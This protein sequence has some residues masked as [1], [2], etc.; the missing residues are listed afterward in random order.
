[1]E[2][3]TYLELN[4]TGIKEL[5]ESIEN[6]VSLKVLYI[7]GCKELESL[8]NSLCNLKNLLLLDLGLCSTLQKLPPLPPFLLILK[9]DECERL[10]YIPELPSLLFSLSA[11][12]CTSLEYI[13]N[14]RDPSS[15]D[16]NT[17]DHKFFYGDVDFDG[18]EKLD[19]NIRNSILDVKRPVLQVLLRTNTTVPNSHDFLYP[20][21][22]TQK[23]LLGGSSDK[24]SRIT[25]E[26]QTFRPYWNNLLS[27]ATCIGYERHKRGHHVSLCLEDKLNLLDYKT[28]GDGDVRLYQHHGSALV[29]N[30]VFSDHVFMCYATEPGPTSLGCSFSYTF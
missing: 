2:P 1:M 12:C 4:E 19:Q 13:S 20:G 15:Q 18:C 11:R 29:D 9:L 3:L 25:I 24:I 6:P 22:Q 26:I 14:W 27:H 21:V 5:P 10:K 23:M 16:V 7:E 30:V 17:L 28:I 8:P